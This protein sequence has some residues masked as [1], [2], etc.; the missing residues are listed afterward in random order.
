MSHMERQSIQA[1]MQI[2]PEPDT[3]ED[4]QEMDLNNPLHFLIIRAARGEL[5]ARDQPVPPSPQYEVQPY[6]HVR[7][8]E[9]VVR[10]YWLE[11]PDILGVDSY[12]RVMRDPQGRT[13]LVPNDVA[14]GPKADGSY[15]DELV[16]PEHV[17]QLRKIAA[18]LSAMYN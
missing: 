15:I 12:F 5:G 8:L 13:A 11:G 18:G 16:R 17:A 3:G 10:Q 6:A 1:I 2:P 14:T 4:M 7:A 9:V